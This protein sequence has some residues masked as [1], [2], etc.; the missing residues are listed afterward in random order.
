VDGEGEDIEVLEMSLHEAMQ[1]V[2]SGT[3]HD[4]KKLSGLMDK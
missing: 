3:I 1:K 4:G 2:D